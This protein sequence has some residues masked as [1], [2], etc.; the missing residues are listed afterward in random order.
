MDVFDVQPTV[1][2]QSVCHCRKEDHSNLVPWD[3]P[4]LIVSQSDKVL[5]VLIYGEYNHY[6]Y[7][8]FVISITKHSFL[9]KSFVLHINF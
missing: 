6:S 4:A 8:Y 5:L 9:F 3:T 1:R 2:E 7:C